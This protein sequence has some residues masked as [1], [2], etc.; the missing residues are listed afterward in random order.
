[1]MRGQLEDT[2]PTYLTGDLHK[3]VESHKQVRSPFRET[4][5]E[6]GGLRDRRINKFRLD[7]KYGVWRRKYFM[8][9]KGR[10][11]VEGKKTFR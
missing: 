2:K 3:R 7:R 11:S 6:R 4:P 10:T 1:M 8:I 9:R 5:T